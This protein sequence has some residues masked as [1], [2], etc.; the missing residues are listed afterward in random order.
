VAAGGSGRENHLRVLLDHIPDIAW[1]K[2]RDLRF[3]AV[4][5]PFAKSCGR[6]DPEGLFGLTDLDVWPRDLAER[7]RED[8]RAVMKSGVR[9]KVVEPFE[10]SGAGR[11]WIETIKAPLKDADGNVVGTVGIARDVS[12][13]V[14]LEGEMSRLN[15][16]LEDRVKRRTSAL[17]ETVEALG[18]EITA[19]RSAED[20]LRAQ[21]LRLRSV[22]DAAPFGAHL[23]E[24]QADGRLTFVGSNRSA[25]KILGL[26]HN[27]F[28]GKAIEEAFPALAHTE[29]P[30]LYRQ[31]ASKGGTHEEVRV[32]YGVGQM[33]GVF[34]IRTVQTAPGQVATFF[35]DITERHKAE[36]ERARL[37]AQ[38]HE[39]QKMEAIGQLA[40]GVA[41][42]FNNLLSVIISLAGCVLE[43][44]PPSG[45]IRADMLEIKQAGQRAAALTRQLLTFSRKQ[46]I[47]PRMLS[48][49]EAVTS[50]AKM[51][52]RL[53]GEH[54]DLELRLASD[55]GDILMDP[56]QF[57]QVI[58]NLVVNARDAMPGGGKLLIETR[59]AM[60]DTEF[61]TQHPEMNPG[62]YVVISVIDNGSGIPVEIQRR[63]FEPFFT[64]KGEGKGTGLGLAMVY[65]A[66]KQNEG[67]IQ[68]D[69]K[70]GAGTT[71]SLFF[72]R[73]DSGDRARKSEDDV[74]GL[75]GRGESVLLV[76]DDEQVRN[77]IARLLSAGGYRVV[78]ASG[79]EEAVRLFGGGGAFDMVLTDVIMPDMGGQVLG[80]KLQEAKPGLPVLY[81]SGYTGEMLSTQGVLKQGLKLISKP[82]DKTVLLRAVR[83]LLDSRPATQRVG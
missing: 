50:L 24:L 21:E 10:D 20:A 45:E 59:N 2:D 13:R 30:A 63:I 83:E 37:E 64:T 80:H 79:G 62:A 41:H 44:L 6:T 1:L 48:P 7:Y 58:T 40:G 51:L 35:Q 3:I 14:K 47:E 60:L 5:E 46:V 43:S 66:V 39:A 27:Q 67:C 29:V 57:D 36:R 55:A 32:D 73:I 61:T 31:I 53:I 38:F 28:I 16:E 69:S 4:N 11:V 56:T 34:D 68:L 26:D 72:A 76:E 82:I 49:N 23:Y 81:C 12:D 52:R 17:S 15:A 25:D 77:V 70:P 71:F 65:G 78:V 74:A 75:A 33:R 9:K 19:R 18:L 54:I 22:I 8:D 42:D